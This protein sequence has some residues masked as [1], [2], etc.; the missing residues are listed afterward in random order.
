[1]G[2]KSMGIAAAAEVAKEMPAVFCGPTAD[3]A[4]FVALALAVFALYGIY[5]M[6]VKRGNRVIL[7]SSERHI[8]E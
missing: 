4:F 1:M 8:S 2:V 6:L 5:K 7:D 3:A